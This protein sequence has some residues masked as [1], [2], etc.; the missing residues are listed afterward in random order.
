H[1]NKESIE[2]KWVK[3]WADRMNELVFIGQDLDKEALPKELEACL[4][5]EQE[6]ADYL[7][8]KKFNDPFIIN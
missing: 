3:D 4:L 7:A 5:N 6:V 1:E 2:G 8:G